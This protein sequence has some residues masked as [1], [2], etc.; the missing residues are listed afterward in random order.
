MLAGPWGWSHRMCPGL[1]HGVWLVVGGLGGGA[2]VFWPI[3]SSTCTNCW[4]GSIALVDGC[5]EA[6]GDSCRM[7]GVRKLC[8]GGGMHGWWSL[9][10]FEIQ[11]H[12]FTILQG[13]S[14]K[15]NFSVQPFDFIIAW[16]LLGLLILHD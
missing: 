10:A 8:D 1:R 11:H 2:A 6:G 14:V 12:W 7:G 15:Q 13:V 16:V 3:V 9:L 5:A 4:T